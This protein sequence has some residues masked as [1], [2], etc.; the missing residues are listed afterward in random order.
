M[1]GAVTHGGPTLLAV[2]QRSKAV[3]NTYNS[4][5]FTLV[6]ITLYYNVSIDKEFR[7]FLETSCPAEYHDI[8]PRLL[9]QLLSSRLQE[10]CTATQMA[11]KVSCMCQ[12]RPFLKT[13]IGVLPIVPVAVSPPE[14]TSIDSIA[15]FRSIFSTSRFSRPVR[16]RLRW[17]LM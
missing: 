16:S 6:D 4:E 1:L 10:A 15:R 13:P 12:E 11:H 3:L 17:L 14:S 8:S 2:A 7:G 5:I 9:S